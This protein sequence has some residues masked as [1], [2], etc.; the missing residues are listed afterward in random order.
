MTGMQ[1]R[2]ASAPAAFAVSI[3]IAA[4]QGGGA[5]PVGKTESAIISGTPDTGDPAVVAIVQRRTSCAT[6]APQ[7][8]CT[9]TL[10]APR[11]VLTAAHCTKASLQP[12]NFEVYFGSHDG[13]SSEK[14]VR[15]TSIAVDPMWNDASRE[16]DAALFQIAETMAITPAALPSKAMDASMVGA[17]LRAVGFGLVTLSQ[18]VPDGIKRQGA[19]KLDQ[20]NALNF[21]ATPDAALT[22]AGD[23]GGPVFMTVAGVEELVG[24]TVSGDPPCSVFATNTRVD[25]VLDT[26]IKP[27]L[28]A[29]A[30]TTPPP[31]IL[32]DQICKSTCA[33]D[34]D[35]PE[36]L[37][38]EPVPNDRNKRCQLPAISAGDFGKSCTTDS[39][40]GGTGPCARLGG[41]G[42]DACRCF[43]SC[44]GPPNP[45]D[46]DAAVDASPPSSGGDSGGCSVQPDR[47]DSGALA[48]LALAAVLGGAFARR[49]NKRAQP[50]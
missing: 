25:T 32:A 17:Q 6:A 49:R 39:D 4:C 13:T 8:L 41:S 10:I 31:T 35:C 48:S 3:T 30:G 42:V 23:S 5:A 11:F 26:F 1:T 15:V 20:V 21:R 34:F 43:H 14:Y 38:C 19:M 37:A 36:Q 16:H 27:A 7:V 22:C 50:R 47:M 33:T 40:C 24:L 18:G 28:M 29:D 2:W 12:G 44:S 9:G 46:F 45:P